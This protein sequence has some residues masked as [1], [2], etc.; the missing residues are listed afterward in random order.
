MQVGDPA[1]DTLRVDGE[2][3]RVRVVGEGANL[4]TTQ[5]S[6]IAFALNG[7]R[8]NADFIDNRAGVDLSENEGNINI[9]LHRERFEGRLV[10]DDSAALLGRLT[11]DVARLEHG[12]RAGGER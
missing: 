1:N 11:E 12:R 10:P 9:A 6:R 3:L 2:D 7:G 8:T 4:G 5:A